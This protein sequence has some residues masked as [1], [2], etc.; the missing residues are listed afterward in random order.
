MIDFD[1]GNFGVRLRRD[2]TH[3]TSC[4]NVVSTEHT[5]NVAVIVL[6]KFCRL[7]KGRIMYGFV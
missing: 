5:A 4:R 6:G 3:R 2:M 1:G 7:K